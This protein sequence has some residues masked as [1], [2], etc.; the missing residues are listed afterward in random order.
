MLQKTPL[1]DA[2]A[3]ETTVVAVPL[4]PVMVVQDVEVIVV[5][6]ETDITCVQ[7]G[8]AELEHEDTA[9]VWLG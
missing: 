9:L 7:E 3:E 2:L 4:H 8:N 5:E 6:D 1:A